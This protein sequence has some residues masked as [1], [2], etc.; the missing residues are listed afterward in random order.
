VSPSLGAPENVEVAAR[1]EMDDDRPVSRAPVSRPADAAAPAA[2]PFAPRPP[3]QEVVSP[4]GRS[5]LVTAGVLLAIGLALVALD[6]VMKQPGGPLAVA[7]SRVRWIG[8]LAAGIGIV[9]A[10]ASFATSDDD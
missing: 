8:A 2:R 10:L 4:K 9:M 7:G 3:A 5:G 6:V 1:F